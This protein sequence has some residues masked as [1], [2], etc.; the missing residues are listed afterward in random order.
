VERWFIGLSGRMINRVEWQDELK[1]ILKGAV[2]AYF[3]RTA[4]E[5]E[6]NH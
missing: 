1:W 5:L 2:V 4:P 3:S 6:E